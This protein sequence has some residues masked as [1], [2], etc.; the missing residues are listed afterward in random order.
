MKETYYEDGEQG[1]DTRQK[2]KASRE[3]QCRKPRSVLTLVR[4]VTFEGNR[5]MDIFMGKEISMYICWE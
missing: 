1:G 2:K 3:Y 5:R 4:R